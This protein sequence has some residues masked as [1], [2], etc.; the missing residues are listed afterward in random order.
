MNYKSLANIR[1]RR[2]TAAEGVGSYKKITSSRPRKPNGIASLQ[3]VSPTID[4]CPLST[5][6][7][8]LHTLKA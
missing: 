1:L 3:M 4:T 2:N 8:P 7:Q 5:D 6:N